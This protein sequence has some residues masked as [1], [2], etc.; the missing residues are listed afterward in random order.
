MPTLRRIVLSREALQRPEL[1]LASS[2]IRRECRRTRL[3]PEHMTDSHRESVQYAALLQRDEHI[4]W[5]DPREPCGMPADDH[6]RLRAWLLIL[7]ILGRA[8]GARQEDQE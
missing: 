4:L 8:T 5:C 3:L 6:D 2:W 7:W 1:R